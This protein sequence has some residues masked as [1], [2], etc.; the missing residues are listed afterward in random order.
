MPNE[1]SELAGERF[2]RLDR[3]L[4]TFCRCSDVLLQIES[5]QDALQSI[6]EILVES[7]EFRLAWI[8]IAKTVPAEPFNL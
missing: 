8:G 6:C 5:E 2:D 7:D 4:R 3:R 1:E